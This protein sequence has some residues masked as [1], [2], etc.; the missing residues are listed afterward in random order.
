MGAKLSRNAKRRFDVEMR[1]ARK[2]FSMG[3]IGVP[4]GLQ[5]ALCTM[6][7][8]TNVANAIAFVS[9]S[10]PELVDKPEEF[11]FELLAKLRRQELL[12]KGLN[13]K[14]F[15]MRSNNL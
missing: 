7:G 10:R 9:K 5:S 3:K 11:N 1:T 8:G 13:G 14:R 4:N 6:Y 15:K 12:G 2:N